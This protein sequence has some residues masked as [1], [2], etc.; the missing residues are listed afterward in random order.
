MSKFDVS[1]AV[2]GIVEYALGKGILH[3]T[4][5]IWA[6][7]AI[8]SVL[9]IDS[10]DIAES[11][12]E[13]PLE[14]L[15][16]VLLDDAAER[17]VISNSI[18]SLDLFDTAIMGCVTPRPSKVI[19]DFAALYAHNP[20]D[21]TDWFYRFC[22]DCNYIREYRLIKDV[23]WTH[24]SKYGNMQITINLAKPEKDPR[25]I[26][27]ALNA[28]KTGY[29]ACQLCRENEGYA[30]RTD[31]PARQN[32]RI[33]PV[34]ILGAPWGLQY[35]PYV[36]YNEHCIVLNDAHTPMT[37]NAACFR[38]LFDFLDKF[39]HYFI[40]SN[41]D[42]PIVGGSILS[43]EHFQGGRHVF[44]IERA[45]IVEELP[46]RDKAVTCGILNWPM[47]T[48]RLSGTDSE[49]VAH[50]ADIILEV[51]R[52][53]DDTDAGILSKTDGTPHNTVTPIARKRG[54]R[55]ELDIVLRNNRTTPEHPLGLFHPHQE[56]HHIK[57]E[58]IGLIEVMGLAIL[59]PHLKKELQTLGEMM[60]SDGNL[61]A[62]EISLHADW[63]EEIMTRRQVT[64]NNIDEVLRAEVGA[65]FVKC[66]EH[67]GVF[68]QDIKGEIAFRHFTQ[69]LLSRIS[70]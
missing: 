57:K 10:L 20:K 51:W 28:K 65:V 21:A 38:K 11:P 4:D 29:P 44:P 48:L 1:W 5:K 39:P 42:L 61:H 23:K 16:D 50:I 62:S 33:V 19:E 7:N 45:E 63:A 43:H 14:K 8:L 31:Y 66:L 3:Q 22:M 9:K 56:L 30:G 46:L 64:A 24:P 60:V 59:P 53:Y 15:L 41:A 70:G 17:G 13:L 27:A 36:Y 49:K 18:V 40:G 67:A 12:A 6:V 35:S 25:D 2:S 55:Y 68:G 47:A 58:N 37:I 69:T 54:E 52:G 32:L 26:A 34:D